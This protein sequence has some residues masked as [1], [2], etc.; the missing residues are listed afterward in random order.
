MLIVLRIVEVSRADGE[1][2]TTRDGY[3]RVFGSFFV[4]ALLEGTFIFILLIYNSERI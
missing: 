1:P 2:N 4:R 3:G